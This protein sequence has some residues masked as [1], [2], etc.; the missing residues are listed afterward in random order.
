MEHPPRPE[1]LV[2]GPGG[3]KGFLYLGFLF[4]CT[5]HQLLSET[6]IYCGV[7]VGS[8]IALLLLVGYTP[9]EIIQEALLFEFFQGFEWNFAKISS[10]QGILS[11]EPIRDHL[12]SLVRRKLG[13]IPTLLELQR[14]TGRVF[15]A[16]T[17]DVTEEKTLLLSPATDPDTSCLDAVIFS[18]SIPLLFQ[19]Q[20]YRGNIC[21]DGAFGNP[22]PLDF[23]DNG[24]R[25]ILAIYLQNINSSSSTENLSFTR[26]LFKIIQSAM[27]Q[28]RIAILQNASAACQVVRLTTDTFDTT[29]SFLT[30]ETKVKMV[31]SGMEA[32]RNY[33]YTTTYQPP[34]CEAKV[35]YRE[36]Q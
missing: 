32:A 5:S 20:R 4:E 30:L 12:S 28:R 10:T 11:T 19:Q 6:R 7:S 31:L 18:L 26:Y 23:F 15:C 35:K 22:L 13:S 9:A 16:V 33:R 14:I 27:D 36:V 3:S 24:R 25:K 21:I 8:I 2:I 29:G 17:H 1:V 34:L